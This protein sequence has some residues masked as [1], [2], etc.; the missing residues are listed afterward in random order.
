MSISFKNYVGVFWR[1][2]IHLVKANL[3]FWLFCLPVVTIPAALTGLHTVCADAVRGKTDGVFKTFVAAGK[4]KFGR[5]LA[6]WLL[7]ALL[8]FL[9]AT[10][11]SFYMGLRS[12][13]TLVLIP[14]GIAL[15]VAMIAAA[16]LPYSFTLLAQTDLGLRDIVKNSFLMVFLEPKTT[17]V[18]FLVCGIWIFVQVVFFMKLFAFVLVIGVS[19]AVFTGTYFS[20]Y[21][22]LKRVITGENDGKSGILG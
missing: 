13:M 14:E 8:F 5:S 9:S 20:M 3:L 11:V 12:S 17:I 15:A 16:M 19:L 10:A 22:L 18:S 21:G 1:N 6:A 7:Y 4:E 2:L